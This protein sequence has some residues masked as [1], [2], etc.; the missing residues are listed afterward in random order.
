MSNIIFMDVDGP[1]IPLRMYYDG[2]RKFD[3]QAGSFV[4]DPVA[5]G[6]L[7][8]LC[9]KFNAQVVFNSAHCENPH[10]IMRHQAR[11]NGFHTI[12]H[13]DCKTKFCTAIHDRYQAIVDWIDRNGPISQWIVV[14]DMPVHL[15]RQVLVNYS[16]GITIDDYYKACQLFTG[17]M[18]SAI[19]GVGQTNNTNYKI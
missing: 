17:K 18:P 19:I 3:Y 5:V 14:D 13:D 16:L 11:F 4:Y 9:N 10:E 8:S 15:P 1:L 7:H 12:L 6:M 2:S